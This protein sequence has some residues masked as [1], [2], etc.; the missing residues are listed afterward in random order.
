METNTERALQQ[1]AAT[2]TDAQLEV[3]PTLDDLRGVD[4]VL[5]D[6]EVVC[7]GPQLPYLMQAVATGLNTLAEP[8]A[9]RLLDAISVGIGAPDSGWVLS[10]AIDVLC[11]NALLLEHLASK[12]A[13]IL[14]RHADAAFQDG[15]SAAL[16]HPAL[17]GLLR[18]SMSEHVPRHRLLTLLSEI[19]GEEPAM[20]LE[21][22]PIIIGVAHD[23]F[24]DS[25]LLPVLVKLADN[26][27]LPP[28][29]R[30]DAVL[31]LALA[32][33]HAALSQQNQSAARD[34]LQRALM[35]LREIDSSHEGRFDAHA[36]AAAIDALLAFA[37][38]AAPSED[39]TALDRLQ[40]AVD[41]LESSVLAQ[42]A[43]N[44]GHHD[45]PWLAARGLALTAWAQLIATLRTA[46]QHLVQPSWYDAAAAL[47]DLMEVYR[48]NRAVKVH[49]IHADNA[50]VF[51]FP[52]IE[53][54]FVQRAGLLHHLD[55][56]LA[57]DPRFTSHPDAT[58]LREAVR[59]R[60]IP[61]AHRQEVNL[62]KDLVDRPALA[63]LFGDAEPAF[64]ATIDPLLLDAVENF[65]HLRTQAFAPTGNPRFDRLVSTLLDQLSRSPEWEPPV[66]SYFTTL[67]EHVLRFLCSRFDA[68]AD[69]YGSRTKYLG[70]CP[71][72]AGGKPQIWEEKEIQDD[73]HE[74]LWGQLTPGTIQREIIDIASGR[75]DIT[76]TPG[77]GNRFV[78]EIKRRKSKAT[79]IAVERDYLPQATNYTAT[80]PPFGIL[81][82]G[83][84]GPHTAGYTSLD[85]SVW[86][87]ST[88]RS[89]TETPRLMVIGVLPVGRPTPSDVTT[90]IDQ[91]QYDRRPAARR[92]MP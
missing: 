12:A 8:V 92:S 26:R 58:A 34:H 29:A 4:S 20:A 11:G 3:G 69:L 39:P 28:V 79:K 73:L 63:G 50:E 1:W 10:D 56:A 14:S 51:V 87:T 61:S 32:D 25:D 77:P 75:T 91:R 53:S 46:A 84:H 41:F 18:L 13:R 38:L 65:L 89:A 30:A 24:G 16:A 17:T 23:H 43:W 36:Y 42:N 70:P 76:Y 55:Q 66:S 48:A 7:R 33:I 71:P 80:G 78:I 90:P 47:H 86:I 83:D 21:R 64:H 6:A 67:L 57:N 31:E 37:D 81:I 5:A 72:D 35:R 88:T 85:D 27:H 60:G 15:T 82:V 22:L 62:G 40:A 9:D 59:Q 74:H 54:A 44:S 45:M 49:A 19:T 52:T 68:Q 2:A